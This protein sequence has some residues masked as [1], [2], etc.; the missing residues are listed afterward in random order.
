M[1]SK[2]AGLCNSRYDCP[3]PTG[4]SKGRHDPHATSP[5]AVHHAS[6]TAECTSE[7]ESKPCTRIWRHER[8]AHI[9]FGSC[10]CTWRSL[11]LRRRHRQRQTEKLNKH[12]VTGLCLCCAHPFNVALAQAAGDM[13]KV[14]GS[15]WWSSGS[16]RTGLTPPAKYTLRCLPS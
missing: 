7:R 11:C 12:A 5:T 14:R 6:L 4:A 2:R 3:V 13:C 8:P 16:P 9:P 15:R 10:A 1:S